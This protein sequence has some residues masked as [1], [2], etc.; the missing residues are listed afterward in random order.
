MI[1]DDEGYGYE[2]DAMLV[3]GPAD[4]C[5]DIAIEIN[6]NKPPKI[7]K[8]I[9]DGNEM[10]RETLGEKLIEY[11]TGGHLDGNQRVAV[12]RLR[13][14]DDKNEKCLYDYAETILMSDFRLK[15]EVP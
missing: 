2:W 9:V 6:G 11:L 5:L 1:K 13:Q 3:G 4:G 12:Y 7:L 10:E 8:R 14:I 15:Y